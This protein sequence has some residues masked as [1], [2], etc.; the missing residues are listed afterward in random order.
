MP[1]MKESALLSWI[2]GHNRELPPQ[3]SLPPGDD[4][5]AVRFPV[6]A[7]AAASSA[8][9][10]G[11]GGVDVLVAVD[12]LADGVHVDVAGTPLSQ[13]GRK[14]I[15]RNLSDV[16]AMAAVPVAA[17]AAGC[18]PRDFGQERAEQLFDGL[19]RAAAAFDCP[20]VGGD[21]SMW[22][23]PLLLSVTVLARA[24]AGIAPV[25]RS[26]AAADDLICVTGR[27]GGSLIEL[28]GYTHHLDFEPRLHLARRLAAMCRPTAMIDLSDGLGADL[29]RVVAAAAGDVRLTAEVE[30]AALPVS[31][32]ATVAADRSG[33]PAWEHAVAD[34]EDY[35][36]LFTI[37]PTL[38]ERHLPSH[39]EGVPITRIGRLRRAGGDEP[40]MV[41]VDEAGQAHPA[42]D[43]GWEHQGP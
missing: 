34:G 22:D 2:Y 5:G 19:R 41:L 40:A 12:Q 17:V 8:S 38:A 31:E 11:G 43:L 21:I 30:L 6:V 35:E 32:A 9:G 23:H 42:L 10:G 33:R 7:D 36:L 39:I 37:D 28:H 3:V 1:A 27:L 4:M 25:R 26:G 29:P 14:A 18:L 16:A 13:V 24:E 20:L 15:T